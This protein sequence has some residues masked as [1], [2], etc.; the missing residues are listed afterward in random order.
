MKRR[1]FCFVIFSVMFLGLASTSEAIRIETPSGNLGK[2]KKLD[3]DFETAKSI[4]TMMKNCQCGTARAKASAWLSGVNR[5]T[6]KQEFKDE[7]VKNRHLACNNRTL[8]S[9]LL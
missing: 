5:K 9:Q 4:L 1:V 7:Q 3:K 2:S 6:V 8:S